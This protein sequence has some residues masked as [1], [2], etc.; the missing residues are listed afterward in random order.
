M[1]QRPFL[2]FITVTYQAVNVLSPTLDRFLTQSGLSFECLIIDGGS[3]DGTVE[4]IKAFASRFQEKTIPFRW[5][6]EPDG[7]LYHAMNK[8]IA[9]AQGDYLW[10]MNAGDRLA[11]TNT[12]LQLN[13]AL[14]K[15]EATLTD[16][17]QALLPDFIYGETMIVGKNYEVI[18]PRRLRAPKKLTWKHFRW[19][20]LVCHQAML[21]K[22][23]IAPP[24][25]TSYRYSADFDWAIR[26]LKASRSIQNAEI[27]LCEFMEG[28]LT[29]QKMA[30]SLKERFT[31]MAH[32]YG[33]AMTTLVHGWFVVRAA[34][35]KLWHGWI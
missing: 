23:S 24:F 26:C 22:R 12:L 20:M 3:N 19:G 30:A 32:H 29:N 4:L 28:G 35:F 17:H 9:M 25:D 15:Q 16:N 33:Y 7:G 1:T 6:S 21:V 31:L 18:G 10:F 27:V 2:S 8:G 5:I 34:W 14:T 13:Q 11:S